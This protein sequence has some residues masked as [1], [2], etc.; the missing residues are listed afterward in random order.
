MT[1]GLTA[2]EHRLDSALFEFF[3]S[4]RLDINANNAGWQ[5]I[6]R[7]QG[8]V[9]PPR[10][11]FRERLPPDCARCTSFSLFFE[12]GDTALLPR[13][14][15]SAGA[16]WVDDPDRLIAR[17]IA[18]IQRAMN[19]GPASAL[20]LVGSFWQLMAGLIRAQ[21]ADNRLIVRADDVDEPAIV[22][23]AHQFMR[24]HLADPIRLSD[25]ANHIGFSESGF[26]HAYRQATG[27]TPMS[28]LRE[29]RIEAARTLLH[30]RSITLQAVAARTGFADAFHLSRTF[31]RA[32][33]LSPSAYR[34]SIRRQTP[35]RGQQDGSSRRQP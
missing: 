15:Q 33:G 32:V 30:R 4:G 12:D 2:G 13:L 6:A 26:S 31:K 20:L 28:V 18:D 11:P 7:G 27:Q 34:Q 23:Q 5:P 17:H 3:L 35:P 14:A 29:M 21:G 10:T 22:T 1:P 19:P 25:L 8:V 24:K 9:Y 16:W